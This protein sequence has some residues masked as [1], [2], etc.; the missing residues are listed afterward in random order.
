MVAETGVPVVVV[1]VEEAAT[2][3]VVSQAGPEGP[4]TLPTH[5]ISA[6]IAITFMA[7]KRG[8]VSNPSPVH[9]P[10]RSWQEPEGPASLK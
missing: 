5:Q 6:V 4:S 8:F 9:G 2:I 1:V 7:I 3:G 10:P